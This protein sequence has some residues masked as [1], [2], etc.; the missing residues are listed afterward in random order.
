[1]ADYRD[2][3]GEGHYVSCIGPW[4]CSCDEIRERSQRDAPKPPTPLTTPPSCACGYPDRHT[5]LP[6]SERRDVDD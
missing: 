2:F 5:N 3:G 1:M 4:A 6:C